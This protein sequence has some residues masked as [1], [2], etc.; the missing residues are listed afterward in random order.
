M[1]L[2]LFPAAAPGWPWD[3]SDCFALLSTADNPCCQYPAVLILSPW[4]VLVVPQHPFV[5]DGGRGRLLELLELYCHAV[6][7]L[8]AVGV[9]L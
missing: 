3:L 4:D 7:E 1:G 9:W 2:S 8:G 5:L 6:R